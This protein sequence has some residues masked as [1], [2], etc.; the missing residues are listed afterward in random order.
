MK[1]ILG[2]TGASGA[3]YAKKIIEI[4]QEIKIQDVAVIFTDAGKQ[5]WNY[6]IENLPIENIP[7]KIYENDNFFVPFASG[8]SDYNTMIICPCSMGTMAKIA[9]GI[10]D[11]LLTRSADVILK[12]NKKLIIVPR[13]TPLNL[14]HIENMKKLKLAGADIFPASPNFYSKPKTVNDLTSYIAK[15]ILNLAQINTN[16]QSWNPKNK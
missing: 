9:N 8:A 1:I 5:V 13:E 14:I 11:N 6:E 7:F 16:F 3:I 15:R 2:I 10:A 4:L 12:E